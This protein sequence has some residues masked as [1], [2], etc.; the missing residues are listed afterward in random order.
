[1]SIGYLSL[2]A[3]HGAA[4]G[5]KANGQNYSFAGGAY[6]SAISNSAAIGAYVTNDVPGTTRVRGDLYLDGG[7]KIYTR[8]TFNSGEFSE[9]ATGGATAGTYPVFA[10]PLGGAW[11][12]FEIKASTN[13]FT[14]L[15]YY[16]KSWTNT[17]DATRG[18][19]NALAYFTDDHAEDVRVWNLKTQTNAI[20]EMLTSTNSEVETVYF[21]PSHDCTI[22]WSEWMSATNTALVW[23][24]VRVDDVGFEMNAS[25]T[26]QHW[27]PI[28]PASWDAARTEP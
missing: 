2:G 9:L 24:F 7:T 11:T 3:F 15:V 28:R 10:I 1:V 19:T 21:Y 25:G 17:Q 20:S 8:E 5:R 14:D 23:S 27:S 18:D 12:D 26:Y 13:N 4:I 6:S 22:P 16:Y